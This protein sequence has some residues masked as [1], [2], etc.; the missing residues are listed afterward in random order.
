MP[1]AARHAG[2]RAEALRACARLAALAEDPI[3]G[4]LLVEEA[5]RVLSFDARALAREVEVVKKGGARLRPATGATPP[6]PAAG[7]SRRAPA[8]ATGGPHERATRALERSVLE[9][10]DEAAEKLDPAWFVGPAARGL[11]T[12]LLGP[13]PRDPGALLSDPEQP[14]QELALRV[15]QLAGATAVAEPEQVLVATVRSLEMR[16]LNHRLGDLQKEFVRVRELPEA[17]DEMKRVQVEMQN[18]AAALRDLK[19]A[20]EARRKER[21]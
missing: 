3:T 12:A 19:K 5:A 17:N 7:S 15:G 9:L 8:M 2:D 1:P 4:G 20:S 21:A 6:L 18:T 10:L 11:A 16:A 14:G 13:G